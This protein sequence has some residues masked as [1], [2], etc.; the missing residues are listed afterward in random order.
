[1]SRILH[2]EPLGSLLRLQHLIST[3]NT[4]EYDKLIELFFDGLDRENTLLFIFNSLLQSKDKYLIDSLQE[5][6]SSILIERLN[7]KQNVIQ[8]QKLSELSI[9]DSN[10]INNKIT[11]KL[12]LIDLPCNVIEFIASSLFAYDLVSFEQT[13]RYIASCC[14]T[15]NAS[16]HL[17]G[18]FG[19]ITEE[20]FKNLINI[21]SPFYD[22]ITNTL[23]HQNTLI[24]FVHR[25]KHLH[26]M[27]LKI[28]RKIRRGIDDYAVTK[29][30]LPWCKDNYLKLIGNIVLRPLFK[31]VKHL[32]I[33]M[34][35]HSNLALF[36]NITYSFPNLEILMLDHISTHD[37]IQFVGVHNFSNLKHLQFNSITI[38]TTYLNNMTQQSI[39][40]SLLHLD[41]DYTIDIVRFINT[42]IPNY[43]SIKDYLDPE[44]STQQIQ[45]KHSQYEQLSLEN[46]C[47]ES[48][49][50][51][52][53]L[54][55]EA[56]TNVDVINIAMRNLKQL[57][58][59]TY[60][61]DNVF[62]ALAVSILQTQYRN[63]TVLDINIP[64]SQ[65][66]ERLSGMDLDFSSLR[67]LRIGHFA[68]EVGN[69]IYGAIIEG[70]HNLQ[71]VRFDI[72]SQ[73][74]V[75]ELRISLQKLGNFCVNNCKTLQRITLDIF[76]CRNDDSILESLC[77][78][79]SSM[80]KMGTNKLRSCE[81]I[82]RGL[83][84]NLICRLFILATLGYVSNYCEKSV[85]MIALRNRTEE[86]DQVLLSSSKDIL[87]LYH[88]QRD[89]FG[90][91]F[92]QI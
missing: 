40:D 81:I 37:A 67:T 71:N 75:V 22:S 55:M 36:E 24:S 47:F 3:F 31:G 76:H 61:D 13:N 32:Q 15:S 30:H 54:F 60:N 29:Q 56:F 58:F 28:G 19:Q 42:L 86:W 44:N 74:E 77:F 66:T 63:L 33:S 4:T 11:R 26:S 88:D 65:L 1:M 84:E 17:R 18:T 80:E 23:T 9:S 69:N 39:T 14:R 90:L 5:L 20:W 64:K 46:C 16:K 48:L 35:D 2:K 27:Q 82:L 38:D 6:V 68:S 8:N 91:I 12:S 43:D 45:L 92:K 70:C 83:K 85:V 34:K 10:N 21:N 51:Y 78:L 59:K 73:D 62:I 41:K 53:N 79:F 87:Q 7:Q 25:W 89:F 57:Q 52:D 50:N 72:E 49:E